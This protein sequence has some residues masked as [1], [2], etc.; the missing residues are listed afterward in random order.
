MTSAS[1]PDFPRLRLQQQQQQQQ[2]DIANLIA[3]ISTSQTPRVGD[4]EAP[5]E[6][7]RS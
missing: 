2:Q 6:K 4:R 1:A 3:L 7:G 5:R